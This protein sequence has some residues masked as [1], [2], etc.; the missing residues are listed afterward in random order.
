MAQ[1]L[2]PHYSDFGGLDT[3]SNK[4][5]QNPKTFR[6]GSKNWRYTL[7][8]ELAKRYGFHHKTDLGAGCELGLFEYKYK[9]I[10]TGQS[11]SEVLGVSDAGVLS[12]LKKHR[13]KLSV[14]AASTVYYYSFYYDGTN[15]KFKVYGSSSNELGSVTVATTDSLD[16]LNTAINAL[17]ITG[18]SS[19][20][21][22]EDGTA[23]TSTEKAY[24]LDVVYLEQFDKE[25][26]DIEY[27]DLLYWET[28]VTPYSTDAI[29]KYEIVTK[30]FG[31]D[32][33]WGG[34][35][36]KNLHNSLYISS[37]L[38]LYKYDGSAIY[39]AGLPD[40]SRFR[41][42]PPSGSSGGSLTSAGDYIYAY[43]MCFTDRNGSEI[44]SKPS[45]VQYYFSQAEGTVTGS[46]AYT[47]TISGL[48]STVFGPN[49]QFPVFA[50]ATNGS[51]TFGTTAVTAT[52]T[53]ASPAVITVASTSTYAVGDPIRFSTSGALPTG[54]SIN[55][56]YYISAIPSGTTFRIS[57]T[58]GGSDVN[59]S[60]IQSGTHTA[61]PQF[62]ILTV[63]SGHNIVAGM[64]LRMEGYL[65]ST[66]DPTLSVGEV[67]HVYAPVISVT[68][69]TIK[70]KS[71]VM[72]QWFIDYDD[73]ARTLDSSNDFVLPSGTVINGCYVPDGV[74]E[75]SVYVSQSSNYNTINPSPIYGAYMKVL[76]TA[77]DGTV[78]Y[79]LINLPIPNDS[80]REYTFK[81]TFADGLLSVAYDSTECAELPRACSLIGEWQGQLIQGGRP[82]EY[83]A[84]VNT[85][86]YPNF[87][88]N[89]DTDFI[90][91]F[92]FS[93]YQ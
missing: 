72:P 6:D 21:V 49:R 5:K 67:E 34:F 62:E 27:N 11:L 15:Y 54:I 17:A 76:R 30:D 37:G 23:V 87:L 13:L 64:C 14:T 89:S 93:Y 3:R 40:L 82:I 79:E 91:I 48:Q 75:Q 39:R 18:L 55:T 61:S 58:S 10:N 83:E 77:S 1:K 51:F 29:F 43:Q 73:T 38:F 32:P 92:N 86:L 24:H 12:R 52:I 36:S 68:S 26:T 88:K 81:D 4:M 69:T 44:K 85:E 47:M 16:T 22:D 70:I 42:A 50:C 33:D 74:E 84:I 19:T 20:T 71:T 35:T 28:V 46:N 90:G 65:P 25:A 9:D 7:D 8:D 59:T 60:G 66:G 80:A 78:K 63:H 45:V 2:D 56:T 53:I 41:S 31:N 57:T